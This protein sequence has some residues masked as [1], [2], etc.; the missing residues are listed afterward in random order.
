MA[1]DDTEAQRERDVARAAEASRTFFAMLMAA[2]APAL[3]D[4][5][6]DKIRQEVA[7]LAAGL[8]HKIH[9]TLALPHTG[10]YAYVTPTHVDM[11]P[12]IQ[13]AYDFLAHNCNGHWTEAQAI[14]IVA[15]IIAESGCN[16]HGPAGDKG[17]AMGL[18]QWHADRR[19]NFESH[20]Y[21][22][23][24]VHKNFEDSTFDEQLEFIDYEL[25]QGKEQAAGRML[26]TATDPRE[27]AA[28][29]TTYYERP[30]DKAGDSAK[31]AQIAAGLDHLQG[32]DTTSPV[33]SAS[34]E[35]RIKQFDVA[36]G[37]SIAVAAKLA[38]VPAPG[39]SAIEGRSPQAVLDYIKSLPKGSLHGKRILLSTGASNNPRQ[40]ALVEQQI[41]SLIREA[42]A[43]SVTVL[44]V[45]QRADLGNVNQQLAD[46]T[47]SKQ[48][49]VFAGPLQGTGS[50]EIHPAGPQ[51]RVA[52][53]DGAL[54]A[55]PDVQTQTA[56]TTTPPS[57]AQTPDKPGTT[58]T[59]EAQTRNRAR[60]IFESHASK[61]LPE[62][63]VV[64]A[65]GS[66]AP[67]PEDSHYPNY[68]VALASKSPNE[69]KP[70]PDTGN[71]PA[72]AK[73]PT[74]TPTAAA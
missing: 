46:I 53:V 56:A 18:C 2:D 54:T 33:A 43:S 52:M 37:D 3:H 50:D 34:P 40:L 35:Q 21:E 58:Q 69:G 62:L 61:D 28:I 19:A 29:V 45:G 64:V 26:K 57:S 25:T 24:H 38:G 60:L 7:G 9:P 65:N 49:V 23:F 31:R 47:K 41:D 42:G 55:T 71:T 10:N 48:G 13:H 59:A 4:G 67:K 12:N 36:I 1:D 70:H 39:N 17:Q 44:G 5:S 68:K 15:N 6:T 14:G 22:R 66:E 16:P 63:P 20:Y 32:S 11:K 27:A 72:S 74:P 8:S 73:T 51:E 30:A